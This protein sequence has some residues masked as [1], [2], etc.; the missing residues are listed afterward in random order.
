MEFDWRAVDPYLQRH[1]IYHLVSAGPDR[2][3]P[4]KLAAVL[5]WSF[6]AARLSTWNDA[7]HL[8]ADLR[9]VA[10]V[11]EQSR[12]DGRSSLWPLRVRAALMRAAFRSRIAND[13]LGAETGVV[14]ILARA[15]E[16]PP[17]NALKLLLDVLRV[18]DVEASARRRLADAAAGA[19]RVVNSVS[20]L[21]RVARV[22]PAS[23]QA[24]LIGEAL[25]RARK[26]SELGLRV[27]DLL[28]VAEAAASLREDI[29]DEAAEIIEA[30]AADHPN[31][32]Y[33]AIL[34]TFHLW[35][36]DR[37]LT[38]LQ[39]AVSV[40]PG[41][42]DAAAYGGAAASDLLAI[43]R[44]LQGVADTIIADL[45]RRAEAGRG[46]FVFDR[47]FS[48][49]YDLLPLLSMLASSDRL[50]CLPTITA[51]FKPQPSM[52]SPLLHSLAAAGFERISSPLWR[53]VLL[54]VAA[55]ENRLARRNEL[56][57]IA[58]VLPEEHLESAFEIARS[59][60]S[61][62]D[63]DRL[64]AEFALL[65]RRP[66]GEHRHFVTDR[67]A[68]SPSFASPNSDRIIA[69]LAAIASGASLPE[70]WWS[71]GVSLYRAWHAKTS[72][73]RYY[74]ESDLLPLNGDAIRH[75]SLRIRGKPSH[76]AGVRVRRA[77]RRDARQ[78]AP[79]VGHVGVAQSI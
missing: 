60:G 19:A 74:S 6:L 5:D 9:A 41:L 36:E 48:L 26:V 22:A 16:L 62:S 1:L 71:P 44:S 47:L 35:S 7:G 14:D 76:K 33:R 46:E 66:R 58:T 28:R 20:A 75:H 10:E 54:R 70:G 59:I 32:V 38:L 30:A 3:L 51:A 52:R 63:E 23:M 69:M 53:E 55:E 61:E 68:S 2:D 27:L 64:D 29:E 11:L 65:T 67:L 79:G 4:A 45:A 77:G 50:G 43:G 37:R 31:Q 34:A 12:R 21:L 17:G 15:R 13:R 73:S 42:G 57:D 49:K 40:L 25:D 78:A 18:S 39:C 8:G 72:N 24:G 56:V